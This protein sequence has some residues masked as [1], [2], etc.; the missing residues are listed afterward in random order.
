MGAGIPQTAAPVV[1]H[2]IVRQGTGRDVQLPDNLFHR[3]VTG[4]APK[5]PVLFLPLEGMPQ[6]TVQRDV[7]QGPGGGRLLRPERAKQRFGRIV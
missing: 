6:Q 5:P 7:E 2:G 4:D 3:D 1:L